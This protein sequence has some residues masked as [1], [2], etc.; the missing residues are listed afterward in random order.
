MKKD[1]KGNGGGFLEGCLCTL[2]LHSLLNTSN[3]FCVWN[4]F[5]MIFY[6][7]T[8]L[9]NVVLIST[10]VPSLCFVISS[11]VTTI[12]GEKYNYK[13]RH[14]VGACLHWRAVCTIIKWIVWVKLIEGQCAFFSFHAGC[15]FDLKF[16]T[17]VA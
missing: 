1:S 15:S 13:L 8:N 16:V 7:L 12:W 14:A 10:T 3:L 2:L 9:E 5:H 4:V 17:K 6:V 11:A